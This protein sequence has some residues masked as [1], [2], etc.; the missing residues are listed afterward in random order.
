[1]DGACWVCFLL[2]AF[3]HQDL[4]SLYNGM[5]VCT[6]YHPKEFLGNVVRT[7]VSSKEKIPSTRRILPRGVSNPGR[8]IKQDSESSTL[9]TS[10]CGP[11]VGQQCLTLGD[12]AKAILTWL[13]CSLVSINCTLLIHVYSV[14]L[15]CLH[16]L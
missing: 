12:R 5:H 2:P 11:T 4:L 6:D 9:P 8:Y 7:H 14:V 1:M 3:T 13:R 10:Y 16:Q 15:P